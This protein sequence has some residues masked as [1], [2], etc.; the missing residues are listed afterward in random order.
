MEIFITKNFKRNVEKQSNIAVEKKMKEVIENFSRAKSIAQINNMVKLK[1]TTNCYRVR[2]GD[3][4]AG[5]VVE[6]EKAIF[7]AFG[8][9]KDFYQGF[10]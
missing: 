5:I 8:H 4:R 6:G 10:P 9:R 3:Y 2:L 7:A 1:N